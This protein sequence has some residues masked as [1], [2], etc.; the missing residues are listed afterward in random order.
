MTKDAFKKAMTHKVG[1]GGYHCECCGP[2]D[3]AAKKKLRRIARRI[4]KAAMKN[5]GLT[6]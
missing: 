6:S 2:T 5:E 3:T 4:L 1:V